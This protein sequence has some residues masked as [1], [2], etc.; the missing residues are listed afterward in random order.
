MTATKLGVFYYSCFFDT[1]R[2]LS[3][4]MNNPP[5]PLPPPFSTHTLPLAAVVLIQ[6]R[7]KDNEKKKI[8]KGN[9]WQ[10]NK[11]GSYPA[12]SSGKFR[13]GIGRNTAL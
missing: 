5:R 11:L 7:Q 1:Y 3:Y 9:L 4:N 2:F 8:G 13:K 12:I 10:G 6:H